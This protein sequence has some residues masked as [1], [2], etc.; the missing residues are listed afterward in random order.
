MFQLKILNYRRRLNI[1]CVILLPLI[2]YAVFVLIDS[3]IPLFT[4]GSSFGFCMAGNESGKILRDVTVFREAYRLV[5]LE[6]I[7]A[8]TRWPVLGQLVN[9]VYKVWAQ[10]RLPLTRRPSLDQL[11]KE[12]EFCKRN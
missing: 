11:S 7:Y 10:W 4:V 5:G 8:P 1:K 3:F 9:Q 12:K 2:V 6:W